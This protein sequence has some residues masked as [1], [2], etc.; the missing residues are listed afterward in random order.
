[1]KLPR[2]LAPGVMAVTLIVAFGTS[3]GAPKYTEV[4]VTNAATISGRVV[5]E[6]DA[7]NVAP[8][9]INKNVE[10]CDID[11]GGVRKSPRLLV[12]E[13]G[14]VA[15]AVVY[16]DSVTEGK[17]MAKEDL[18]IDQVGCHYV[19]HITIAP[20]KSKVTLKSSDDILHN[21]HMFGAASYNIPFPDM[22]SVL[23]SFRKSGVVRL[24][25]DAGHGWMSAYIHVMNHPYYAVTDADGKFQLTDIPP[26]EYVLKMW[27]EAWVVSNEVV[28]DGEVV[29]YEFGDPI[30]KDQKVTVDAGTEAN[31]TFSLSSR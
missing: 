13:S 7:A 27:H 16:L 19:P 12:S 15:N 24:Q 23:K 31:V 30:I 11:G 5:W 21:I 18:V 17:A 25:C 29:S 1:M 26:G 4:T 8:M 14:G 28:K 9:A 10:S 20:R 6:G 22:N 2:F 3:A